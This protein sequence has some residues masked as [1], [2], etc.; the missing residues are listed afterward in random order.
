MKKIQPTRI[1]ITLATGP[2]TFCGT[3]KIAENYSQATDHVN[4]F[5]REFLTD[6]DEKID[7]EITFDDG[8]KSRG[9]FKCNRHDYIFFTE[10]AFSGIHMLLSD[11]PADEEFRKFVDKNGD[12]KKQAQ[13]FSDKY[14]IEGEMNTFPEVSMNM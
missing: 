11:D 6:A 2:M 9:T 1:T 3:T 10:K 4:E 5:R 13:E 7:F 8:N 12:R 14:D